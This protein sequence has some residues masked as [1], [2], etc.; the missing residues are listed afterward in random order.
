MLFHTLSSESGVDISQLVCDWR[1]EVDERAFAEAWQHLARRH[2]ILRTSFTWEGPEGPRQHV[3]EHMPV[4]VGLKDWHHLSREEQQ[5]EL[6]KLLEADR[7]PFRL[8][9]APLLR[10]TLIRVQE[11]RYQFVWTIHHL[12]IDG[13]SVVIL[14]NDLFT[15]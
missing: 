8:V 2:S 14:L 1:D 12:M 3:H 7:Q 4:P 15:I 10:V 9:A 6:E 5:T 13:Q 11:A